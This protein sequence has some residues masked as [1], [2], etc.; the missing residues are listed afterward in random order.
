MLL[1]KITIEHRDTTVKKVR[2]AKAGTV[3]ET[4]GKVSTTRIRDFLSIPV[5]GVT[6]SAGV[7]S[8]MIL[9]AWN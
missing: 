2:P 5:K 8:K 1:R 6:G 9:K 7:L 3:Q 4:T